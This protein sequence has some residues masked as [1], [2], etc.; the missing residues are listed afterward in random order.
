MEKRL[1]EASVSG[2]VYTLN[3]LIQEDQLILDRVNIT[4]FDE[5]PLHIAALR[6]HLDFA[7]ALLIRKPQLASELDASRRSPLHLASVQGNAAMVRELLRVSTDACLF[8]DDQGKIPLHLAAMKDRVEVVRQLIQAQPESIKTRARRGET[9]LH[10]SVKHNRFEALKLLVEL[11]SQIDPDL[12]SSKDED[13]NTILHVAA[14]LKQDETIRY[15]FEKEGMIEMANALNGNGFTTLDLLESS[16]PRDLKAME[17]Q[18]LFVKVGVRRAK[19]GKNLPASPPPPPIIFHKTR[20][21]WRDLVLKVWNK[22]LEADSHWSDNVRG[23]LMVVATLTATMAFQ[24]GINPPGGVWQDDKKRDVDNNGHIAG[25]SILANKYPKGHT[26]FVTYNTVSFLASLSVIL[27]VTSGFPMNKKLSVWLLMVALGVAI[28]FM[29][30]TY[31][32]S[33][34]VT[35]P[36]GNWGELVQSYYA[37]ISFFTLVIL[38]HTIR[39][40]TWLVNKL[41]GIPKLRKFFCYFKWWQANESPISNI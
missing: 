17:I 15:L 31:I 39:L 23:N 3:T 5:T 6:G 2:N 22:Y 12:V 29:A 28:S 13:G 36:D 7:R 27:L 19:D 40:F 25:T 33:I 32:T 16:L 18:N 21:K 8:R 9:V 38:V 41:R 34:N 26:V 4:C 20:M 30:L 10:L 35:T 37:C 11:A 24:A 14:A 1:Y